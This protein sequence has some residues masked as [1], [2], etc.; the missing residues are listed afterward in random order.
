[1]GPQM[2][3]QAHTG[4]HFEILGGHTQ[5]V[6]RVRYGWMVGSSGGRRNDVPAGGANQTFE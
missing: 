5:R 6:E 3:S 4:D 1:M 2:V